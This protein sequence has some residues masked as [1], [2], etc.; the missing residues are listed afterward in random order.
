MDTQDQEKLNRLYRENQKLEQ[1]CFNLEDELHTVRIHR[2]AFVLFTLGF[3]F[4]FI[5][6][7][8]VV[9]RER[10]EAYDEGYEAG[11][12]DGYNEDY[13]RSYGYK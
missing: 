5:M 7:G 13:H 10:R 3:L 11:Y 6:M 9:G 2:F 12:E 8:F 1:K 4:L